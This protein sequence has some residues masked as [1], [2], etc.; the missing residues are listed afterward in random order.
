MSDFSE[1]VEILL[2]KPAQ[3]YADYAYWR[4]SG[5]PVAFVRRSGPVTAEEF[6]GWETRWLAE[7]MRGPENPDPDKCE[8]EQFQAIAREAEERSHEWRKLYG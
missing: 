2:Y 7:G 6:C 3:S 1:M 5:V 8:R 4:A